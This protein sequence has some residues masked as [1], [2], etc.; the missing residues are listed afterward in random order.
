MRRISPLLV[1]LVFTV[2]MHAHRGGRVELECPLDGTKFEA[3]QDFSGT[4]FR[5]RLDLKDLGPTASPWTLAQ[6]PKCHLPLSPETR[7][8]EK[9]ARLRQVV[10]LPEFLRA[11]ETGASYAALAVV[12]EMTNAGPFRTAQSHLFASWQLEGKEAYVGAAQAA[13]RWFDAAV[14]KLSLP[15][16]LDE[17]LMSCYVP[18]ELLR[19][20]GQF[21]AADRRI[22]AF[23]FDKVEP[24]TWLATAIA[25]QKTLI[26]AKDRSADEAYEVVAA[27][28]RQLRTSRRK[29]AITASNAAETTLLADGMRVGEHCSY[30]ALN[31]GIDPVKITLE[32]NSGRIGPAISGQDT[33]VTIGT[34]LV[35]DSLE[36]DG[37]FSL[38]HPDAFGGREI[39][40]D[41]DGYAITAK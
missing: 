19:R 37:T 23:P 28:E 5:Q 25:R 29:H 11:H 27:K 35:D 22:A 32:A 41:A 12:R 38:G 14:A 7:D 31:E 6:C 17:Y 39:V 2:V 20:T 21:E 9:E 10:R 3:W 13:I 30:Y 15:D 33:R 36:M 4:S 26:S 16:E 24:G 40:F 1:V 8:P 34:R 18:I